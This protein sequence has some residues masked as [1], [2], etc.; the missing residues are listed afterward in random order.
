LAPAEAGQRV[1]DAG[2][3]Q[4]APPDMKRPPGRPSYSGWLDM[5]SAPLQ[6]LPDSADAALAY[7]ANAL[8]HPVYTRWTLPLLKRGCPSLADAKRDHPLV[9]ALLLDHDAAVEYWERGRL[10]V[11]AGDTVPAPD[12]VL[13]RQLRQHRRFRFAPDVDRI[14]FVNTATVNV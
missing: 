7:V 13:L 4:T 10:R 8:G 9:F 2:D 6:R 3:H 12:T 1:A 11:T 14:D 5:A